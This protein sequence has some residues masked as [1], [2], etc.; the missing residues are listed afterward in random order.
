MQCEHE[1]MLIEI[2]DSVAKK[3]Y[4]KKNAMFIQKQYNEMYPIISA[5]E[6]KIKI[7]R[8]NN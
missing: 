4:R 5:I 1:R 7:N 3:L 8:N 2:A 6:D